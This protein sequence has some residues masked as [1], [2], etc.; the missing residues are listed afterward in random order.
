M[1]RLDADVRQAIRKQAPKVAKKDI[2]KEVE[3]RF[4]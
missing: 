3:K 1:A 2:R 4:N